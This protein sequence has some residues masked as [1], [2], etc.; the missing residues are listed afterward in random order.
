MLYR[1]RLLLPTS[2]STAKT[3][4]SSDPTLASVATP[5][6]ERM[7]RDLDL[8]CVASPSP[9]HWDPPPRHQQS[10]PAVYSDLVNWGDWSLMSSKKIRTS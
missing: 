8:C 10:L 1:T 4:I 6:G 9:H 5:V 2:A 3:L 7:N